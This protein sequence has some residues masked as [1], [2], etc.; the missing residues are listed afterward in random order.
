MRS[1][2]EPWWSSWVREGER[3]SHSWVWVGGSAAKRWKIFLSIHSNTRTHEC[4]PRIS[5]NGTHE[6]E[7]ECEYECEC[8]HSHSFALSHFHIH[9]KSFL[10][11]N[12]LV[13]IMDYLMVEKRTKIFKFEYFQ[14]M[15]SCICEMSRRFVV[16]FKVPVLYLLAMGI[17]GPRVVVWNC[18][19]IYL[20]ILGTYLH[21]RPVVR[22]FSS[23]AAWTDQT[24]LMK[25]LS[26]WIK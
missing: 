13:H 24:C 26:P 15:L 23:S 19:Y 25:V 11:V 4:E 21:T 16:V 7:C 12:V 5:R 22:I 14:C 20:G 17:I 2:T 6:C 9:V 3:H 18:E 10:Q 1:N 8:T